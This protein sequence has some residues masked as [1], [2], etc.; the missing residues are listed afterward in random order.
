M[1]RIISMTLAC[2]LWIGVHTASAE[3]SRKQFIDE[4][5]TIAAEELGNTE[6]PGGGTKYGEW[7]GHRWSEWCAEFASWCVDQA[8]QRLG[9]KNLESLYPLAGAAVTDVN[10]YTACGRYLTIKG[11]IKD[12]GKQ[13]YLDDGSPV[14]DSLYIP[15]RGDLI[16][17][18]WYKYNRIDH[19]GIVD[20]VVQDAAGNYIIHTIEGNRTETVERFSYR[21]DDDSIR[22][23]GVSRMTV[24][25]ELKPGCEGPYVTG[26]QQALI[27][28]DYLKGEPTGKYD[29]ATAEAVK[30]LQKKEQLKQTGLADQATQ[31]ALGYPVLEQ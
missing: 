30:R 9:T 7:F 10:W 22:A 2:M 18:E 31:T 29:G 3:I 12:W 15:Q 6:A 14:A 5:L 1:R 8:D 27:D 4:V 13:W 17:F 28:A 21:L 11:E 19:V 26:F 23:Y 24:G 25:T 16:M 20:F